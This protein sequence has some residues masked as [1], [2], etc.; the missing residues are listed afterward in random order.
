MVRI[1]KIVVDPAQLEAYK[2]AAKEEI[3]A[4][5]RLEPGVLT[6]YAVAEKDNPTHITI[7]EIYADTNAYKAHIQTPHFLKYK[8]GTK[9]M[10]K[11]LELVE[12]DPLVPGM[13]IKE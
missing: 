13:K 7:L 5:V 12:V 6:L 3:E 9:D 1:A 4:S 8:T 2:A 10:V 11:S